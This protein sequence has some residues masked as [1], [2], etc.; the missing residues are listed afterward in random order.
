MACYGTCSMVSVEVCVVW[1]VTMACFGKC[2]MVSVEVCVV[3][4]GAMVGVM[5]YYGVLW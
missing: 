3:C 5:C 4:D 1:C 2:G